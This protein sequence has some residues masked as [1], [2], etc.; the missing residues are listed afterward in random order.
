MMF[1]KAWQRPTVGIYFENNEIPISF[2]QDN[3]TVI[4]MENIFQLAY[5][6]SIS[7][8]NG[9]PDLIYDL[10][11]I[12]SKEQDYINKINREI[13][14]RRKPI[15]SILNKK[16]LDLVL[17]KRKV[18]HIFRI[19]HK[20][21]LLPALKKIINESISYFLNEHDCIIFGSPLC[22]KIPSTYVVSKGDFQ[23]KMNRVIEKRALLDK[24]SVVQS[25]ISVERKDF[26][27][28]TNTTLVPIREK[29]RN[30]IMA[31]VER[32]QSFSEF[33][34]S[35]QLLMHLGARDKNQFYSS[36]N[37]SFNKEFVSREIT[38]LA[39]E[40]NDYFEDLYV[41]VD[42]KK[43]FL[44]A[45]MMNGHV[46]NP[47][48]DYT[49][50]PE[51]D[52]SQKKL[53]DKN[54]QKSLVVKEKYSGKKI[55]FAPVAKEISSLYS[56]G[57]CNLHY[58]NPGEIFVYGAYLEDNVLPFAYSSYGLVS[59]NYTKEMLAFLGFGDNS[60]LESSRAWNAT[61]APEN[62]MSVLFTYS[63]EM[64]KEHMSGIKGI[65][66]SINPNLGFSA[67][68]FRGVH[69]EIVSLKPTI[70]SYQIDENGL[71]HFRSKSEIS[72]KLGIELSKLYESPYY[73]ENRIPF[74]QTIEMLYLYDY[75]ERQKLL[76][77]P[78]YVVSEND[79][80]NNR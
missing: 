6:S 16:F 61:W 19:G 60:I 80:I 38:R 42:G 65:L 64:I 58:A 63:Q 70:F 39:K 59:Y 77:R 8:F 22:L 9:F 54:G 3:F 48:S 56:R 50:H 26:V 68:A 17:S 34:L 15:A 13:S 57:F 47:F 7:N 18:H 27:W 74:L 21:D 45:A 62:T 71:P 12:E 4:D 78:I 10:N 40:L 55:I 29:F 67:S 33:D 72:K 51:L 20:I 76:H 14:I 69:F 11:E 66:T 23:D 41:V 31:E 5:E 30:E 24:I 79:Y 1:M 53:V 35:M 75:T 46:K 43:I 2:E 44:P 73:T 28:S 32:Y 25:K 49:E 52:L 37:S 36:D